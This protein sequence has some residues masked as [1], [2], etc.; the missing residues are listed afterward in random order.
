[1]KYIILVTIVLFQITANAF[2]I[3]ILK[4]KDTKAIIKLPKGT[5]LE[6][7][8]V[9]YLNLEKESETSEVE[10]NSSYGRANFFGGEVDFRSLTQNSGANGT[11]YQIIDVS[12]YLGF[13]LVRFE[14]APM[15][16]YQQYKI[17]LSKSSAWLVGF[18]AD[19]NF[20]ENYKGVDSVWGVRTQVQYGSEDQAGSVSVIRAQ[21][22][23]VYKWFFPETNVSIGSQLGYRYESLS[24]DSTRSGIVVQLQIQTYLELF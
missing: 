19:Y 15:L 10:S 9:Y 18:L 20:N 3:K 6:K 22:G 4:I 8:E 11:E 24:D 17:G 14:V 1:M 23:G 21:V 5:Q 13:N 2:P 7:G 16:S 12:T